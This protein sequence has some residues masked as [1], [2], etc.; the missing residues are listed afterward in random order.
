MSGELNFKRVV[1]DRDN[2][3]DRRL[4]KL[5][6]RIPPSQPPSIHTAMEE[7]LDPPQADLPLLLHRLIII[8]GDE[9]PV[10]D[11]PRIEEVTLEDEVEDPVAF[12]DVLGVEEG[13]HLVGIEGGRRF[14]ELRR[15]VG[16]AWGGGERIGGGQRRGGVGGGGG[17]LEVSG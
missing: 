11:L 3:K 7:I 1:K 10:S 6:F 8:R 17:G 9:G 16:E 2:L 13:A 5:G 14:G 15:G 4:S 12:S